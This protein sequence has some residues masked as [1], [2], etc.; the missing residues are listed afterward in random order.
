[1]RISFLAVLIALTLLSCVKNDDPVNNGDDVD[2]PIT[3]DCVPGTPGVEEILVSG[4]PHAETPPGY[5]LFSGYADPSIR[6]DPDSDTIWL[7]YSYPHYK[8]DQN[9]YA[10]SVE[11]HL[12]RS[13]NSGDSWN[14]TKVLWETEPI[15]N[16]AEPGQQGYLDHETVNLLPVKENGT[17]T[18][19]AVRT[20]YF[21][22]DSGGFKARP[23]N[24]FH[25]TILKASTPESL[26][27]GQKGIFGGSLTHENWNAVKLVPQELSGYYFFWNEPA[28]YYENK[29]IYLPGH[30]E[31]PS[32]KKRS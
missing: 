24:S 28:L 22:P 30:A 29:R 21:I 17:T 19:Y 27:N 10:P 25:L 15:T 9:P 20:N 1:M 6:K 11:I 26:S 14:F 2:Y 3:L 8:L 16:P 7:A 18:W 31:S 4:D 13:E 32:Y 23:A 5:N 12:A